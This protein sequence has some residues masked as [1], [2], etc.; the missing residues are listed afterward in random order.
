MIVHL[1]DGTYELF[2][3]YYGQQRRAS[4]HAPFGAVMGVL[5]TVR[6]LGLRPG[7]DVGVVAFDDAPWATL[8]DPPLSVVRQPAYEMGATAAR[9]LL[10]RIAGDRGEPTTTRLS[11]ELVPRGSST[12]D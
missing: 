6:R 4:S 8:L 9:L 1:I 5:G 3:H 7:R 10:N 2:R 12:P 11:A